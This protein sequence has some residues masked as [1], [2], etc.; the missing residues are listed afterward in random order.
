[1]ASIAAALYL[2][3]G[4]D[5]GLLDRIAPVPGPRDLRRCQASPA[6]LAWAGTGEPGLLV[7]PGAGFALAFDGRLD[8]RDELQYRL[9]ASPEPD[10]DAAWVLAAYRARGPAAFGVLVGDFS[11]ALWDGPRG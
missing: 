1:M 5:P 10:T 6:G 2:A 11:L 8:N 9:D 4:P 7:S 3:P